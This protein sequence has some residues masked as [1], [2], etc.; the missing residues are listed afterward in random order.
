MIQHSYSWAY[1]LGKIIIQKDTCTL[2]VHCNTV[3]SVQDIHAT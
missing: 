2:S 3:Y 1:Y